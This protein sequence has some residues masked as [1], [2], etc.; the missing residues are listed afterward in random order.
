MTN[1]LIISIDELWLK[2]RNQK[3]Y[4]KAVVGHIDN[5]F[6]AYHSDKVKLTKQGQRLYYQSKTPFDMEIIEALLLVPGLASVTPAKIIPLDKE[7]NLENMYEEILKETTFFETQKKTFRACVKKNHPKI[8]QTS[9]TIE[10]EIGARILQTYPNAK[11]SLEKFD[12][13]VEARIYGHYITIS[14]ISYK[15]IGGLPWGSNGHALTLL[16]GGFDSPVASYM[17]SRRGIRQDFV[18]FHAYPFVGREVLVKIK[19]LAGRLAQF[20][21]QAHLYIVPFGDIQTTIAENCQEE[22][23]TMLFRKAMVEVSNLICDKTGAQSLITGDSL[24]QV[25]S[26]TIGNMHLMDKASQRMILRPLVGFN[27]LEIISLATQIK[28]HDIS[29]IPHDDACAL[30]APKNPIINPNLD[31][32]KKV[33]LQEILKEHYETIIDKTEV[34]SINLQGELFKKDFFSYDRI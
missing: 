4:L 30:F 23:K 6:R 28:T 9:V 2:G 27:K 22:Y 24:G 5:V 1:D 31:Y 18:F 7:L 17:I 25:S 13:K 10:R 34:Y 12:I 15:G 32:W 11:V 16:S 29:I 20:Q 8:T 3:I 33:D 14:T 19:K 21:R 26:Q